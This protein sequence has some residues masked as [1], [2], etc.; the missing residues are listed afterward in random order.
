M[1]CLSRDEYAERETMTASDGRARALRCLAHGITLRD[2]GSRIARAFRVVSLAELRD[3]RSFR[4]Y[5]A[6]RRMHRSLAH[7]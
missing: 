4:A 5:Q 1:S 6:R 7:R 3:G 2:G